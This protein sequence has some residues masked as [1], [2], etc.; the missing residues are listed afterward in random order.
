[1]G[2]ALVLWLLA[3]LPAAGTEETAAALPAKNASALFPPRLVA[4]A[5]ANAAAHRWCADIEDRILAAVAR[6]VAG[7]ARAEAGR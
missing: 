7:T 1:M 6:L 3:G 2:T 4:R 5:R